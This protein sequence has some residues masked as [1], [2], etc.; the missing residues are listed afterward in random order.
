MTIIHQSPRYVTRARMDH[1]L[2]LIGHQVL[3]ISADAA[4]DRGPGAL[5]D[6][7]QGK[8][9]VVVVENKVRDLGRSHPQIPFLRFGAQ[10]YSRT[11]IT[12][13]PVHEVKINLGSQAAVIGQFHTGTGNAAGAQVLES[14]AVNEI[15]FF[16]DFKQGITG[17]EQV[18]LEKGVWFLHRAFVLFPF[19]LLQLK[20]GKGGAAKAAVVSRF[21]DQN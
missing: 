17:L 14:D 4:N 15:F 12:H 10:D 7:R 21:A 1:G 2:A 19:F 6:F 20:R 13:A 9:G 11:Q 18:A 3:S 16:K 5:G 8:G